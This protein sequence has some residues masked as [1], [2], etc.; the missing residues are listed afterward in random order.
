M[1]V[2]SYVAWVAAYMAERQIEV[3]CEAEENIG[4]VTSSAHKEEYTD[5]LPLVLKEEKVSVVEDSKSEEEPEASQMDPKEESEALRDLSVVK[6]EKE[7]LDLGET[8]TKEKANPFELDCLYDDFPFGSK[9]S[10]FDDVEKLEAQDPLEK[11]GLG[12]SKKSRAL[13]VS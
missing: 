6:E 13:Y 10:W 11:V 7:N 9:R 1:C 12:D 5:S 3:A 8:M 4:K 2:S